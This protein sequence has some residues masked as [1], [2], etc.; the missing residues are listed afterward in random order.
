MAISGFVI[1]KFAS[2]KWLLHGLALSFTNTIFST[3]VTLLLY[4]TYAANNLQAMA[5]FN[6]MARGH[7]P[8]LLFVA[9]VPV[10]GIVSGLIQGLLAWGVA[11]ALGKR[12]R[13]KTI[14]AGSS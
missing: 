12:S 2:G 8:R 10:I 3:I 9:M 5:E 6:R 11:A 4:T 14:P 13:G 1:A 7:D